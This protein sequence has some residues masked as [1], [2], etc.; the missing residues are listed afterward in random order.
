MRVA[1]AVGRPIVFPHARYRTSRR[2]ERQHLPDTHLS[3]RHPIHER[4][5]LRARVADPVRSGQTR[6]VHDHARAAIVARGGVIIAVSIRDRLSHRTHRQLCRARGHATGDARCG[7]RARARCARRCARRRA[8]A[9][10]EHVVRRARVCGTRGR[11]TRLNSA[12]STGYRS[13]RRAEFLRRT[14]RRSRTR[15]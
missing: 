11:A 8:R 2:H 13:R 15:S 10:D 14:R 9:R 6:G 5:R 4:A 1:S 3:F 12:A 7:R